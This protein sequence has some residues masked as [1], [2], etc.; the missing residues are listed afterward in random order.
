M[1]RGKPFFV[2]Q[3]QKRFRGSFIGR[4]P[5]ETPE[6]RRERE[7]AVRRALALPVEDDVRGR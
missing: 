1:S 6:Q 2:T 7:K 5:F 4:N 3:Y